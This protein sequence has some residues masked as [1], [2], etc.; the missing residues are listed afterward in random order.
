ME[1][2]NIMMP[3][4]NMISVIACFVASAANYWAAYRGYLDRGHLLVF[5]IVVGTFC[6]G[7][8]LLLLKKRGQSK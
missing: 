2:N 3:S 1:K 4:S 6:L 7:I 5:N 8:A